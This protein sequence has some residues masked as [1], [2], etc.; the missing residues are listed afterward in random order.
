ML[1]RRII[2]VVGLVALLAGACTRGGQANVPSPPASPGYHPVYDP[3]QFTATVDNPWFPLKPGTTWVYEGTKDGKKAR[4]VYTVTSDTKVIAGVPCIVVHDSLYL[5]GAL[6]E[7]T[8]DYYSQDAQGNVWYFGEDTKTLDA[9]GNVKS[10]DGTFHA[11]VDGAQPGIFME[12]QP[13]IGHAFRQE[14]YL[15]Q[16]EDQYKVASLSATITVPYGSFQNAQLTNEWTA[17]EPDVLDEK[18]YVKG[19]GEVLEEAVKGPT[20]R[21]QLVSFTSG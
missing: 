11:G 15:G 4:D 9:N 3:S 14:Y 7:E 18:Y 13:A 19:V 16:A 2:A 17:L 5:N 1:S 8:L 10:T 12:A 6:E 21:L 20:E